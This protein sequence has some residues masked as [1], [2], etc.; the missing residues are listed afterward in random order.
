[1]NISIIFF[2]YTLH[3]RYVFN[4]ISRILLM[5]DGLNVVLPNDRAATHRH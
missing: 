4:V 5:T 2:K 3:V 1:M